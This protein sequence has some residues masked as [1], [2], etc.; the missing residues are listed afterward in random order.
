MCVQLAFK[1]ARMCQKALLCVNASLESSAA[2]TVSADTQGSRLHFSLLP[3]AHTCSQHGP[4]SQP[5]LS[6][7]GS[8]LFTVIHSIQ[9]DTP[10]LPNLSAQKQILQQ[11][12]TSVAQAGA[13]M[14]CLMQTQ[15]Q[16]VP[17]RTQC[18]DGPPVRIARMQDV[19][20]TMLLL[21]LLHAS[22]TALPARQSV[23]C[24]DIPIWA[25]GGPRP[26]TQKQ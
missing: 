23:Y 22:L 1:L 20:G 18:L 21:R 9:L 16:I 24:S 17:A 11:L 12:D 2:C 8:Q 26:H 19:L 4:A 25:A 13:H 10:L 7:A 5:L 15:M 3:V 14:H 6:K